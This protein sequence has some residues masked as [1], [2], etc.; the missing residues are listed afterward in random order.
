MIDTVT[1]AER[2]RAALEEW[3]IPPDILAGAAASPWML[4]VKMFAGRAREQLEVPSGLSYEVAVEALPP[5]GHVLDVGAGAGAAS[6]AL[7]GFA[8]E[9]TAVDESEAML[10]T[11]QALTGAAAVPVHT[12][13]GTWP[14]V[15]S[16]VPQADVVL[17]HHVVYNVADLVPFVVALT[18]H[19]RRRVVVELTTHHPAALLNPLWSELHGIERPDRPRAVDAIEVIAS[20]GVNPQW[21]V[22]RRPITEVGTSY[23]ELIASTCRRLCLG[24]ERMGDVEAALQHQGVRPERPYLG[25]AMRD[26]VTIW[27][28]TSPAEATDT[29]R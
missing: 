6:L 10:A 27:W 19:A 24:P 21:Q 15:A 7:R 25:D 28:D 2:W 20:T 14:A 1:A 11:F 22:W 16:T 13:L 8:A 18:D 12:V 23:D 9:V 29:Q 3:R 5:G 4:P 26:L 17:C